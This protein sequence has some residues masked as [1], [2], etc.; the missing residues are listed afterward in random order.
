MRVRTSDH[1][2]WKQPLYQV[3]Y[4]H[5]TLLCH[6]HSIK[7]ATTTLSSGLHN[8]SILL[9]HNHSINCSKLLYQVCHNHSIL[10]SQPLYSTLSQ[11]LYQV[12]HN[13]CQRKTVLGVLFSLFTAAINLFD[14]ERCKML[15]RLIGQIMKAAQ[16]ES[17]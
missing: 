11:P 5:S 15:P 1:W 2:R 17:K 12:Y 13:Q 14:P 16:I 7:C 4:S 3:C 8:H 9:C 6:K 10:L